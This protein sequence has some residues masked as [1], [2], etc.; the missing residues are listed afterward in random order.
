MP[1]HRR[2]T[3]AFLIYD[4]EAS[5]QVPVTDVAAVDVD[6]EDEGLGVLAAPLILGDA[7]PI[8]EP[9]IGLDELEVEVVPAGGLTS[10]GDRVGLG[11]HL[12]AG[13]E[14]GAQKEQ[15]E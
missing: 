7:K 3:G 2:V 15:Q 4:G 6:G 9:F 8:Q 11:Y 14:V 13:V 12:E 10:V 1:N 5:L